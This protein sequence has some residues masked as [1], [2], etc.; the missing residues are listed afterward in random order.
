MFSGAAG[1]GGSARHSFMNCALATVASRKPSAAK[2]TATETGAS[3]PASRK[4]RSSLLSAAFIAICAVH[5]RGQD[6]ALGTRKVG[7]IRSTPHSRSAHQSMNLFTMSLPR[8]K[9]PCCGAMI[10]MSRPR[11]MSAQ[12][13]IT[14]REHM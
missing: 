10:S 6:Q 3:S 8:N 5:H 7:V 2:A 1:A 11:T 13:R 4:N 14:T 9:A 12:A